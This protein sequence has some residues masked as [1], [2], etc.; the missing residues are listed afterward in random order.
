MCCFIA[1]F[2]HQRVR[3][4]ISSGLDGWKITPAVD[5]VPN[6]ASLDSQAVLLLSKGMYF[7]VCLCTCQ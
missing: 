7:G 2:D 3:K 6:F 5:V 1:M 4:L